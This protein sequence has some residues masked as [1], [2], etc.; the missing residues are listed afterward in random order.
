[1]EA[2]VIQTRGKS[3]VRFLRDFAKRMGVKAKTIDTE[4][5]KDKY[6]VSL[7]EKGLET[8]NVSKQ[9]IYKYFSDK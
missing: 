4:K 5:A 6:L 9:D 1:M 2:V 3:D 7:I 8:E